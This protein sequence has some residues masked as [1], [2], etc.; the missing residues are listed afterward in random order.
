MKKNLIRLSILFAL[1][2][3][4]YAPLLLKTDEMLHPAWDWVSQHRFWKTF[5]H[6]SFRENGQVPLWAPD[7]FSGAPFVGH[8][9][10][11]T[12]FYPLNF[13]FLIFDVDSV[14]KI[15]LVLHMILA[16]LFM[17]LLLREY[18]FDENISLFGSVVF[19][20]GSAFISKVNYGQLTNFVVVSYLPLLIYLAKKLWEKPT[21][22][23]SLLFGSVWAL[24]FL[25]GNPHLFY[26]CAIGIGL[27]F[28]IRLLSDAMDKKGSLTLLKKGSLVLLAGFI[29]LGL[30]ACQ[31]LP[32]M[33]VAGWSIRNQ[34]D[35]NFS[36]TMS[37]PPYMLVG[38]AFP[39]IF[40][41]IA[42]N[43]YYG[44]ENYT[45]LYSYSGLIALI[46]VL[47]AILFV[48]KR[49]FYLLL[50]IA[51]F[52][53]LLA[54]G[55]Y[56]PLFSIAYK[57]IPGLKLFRIPS[58]FLFLF[59]FFT[60]VLSSYGLRKYI[61][62]I[63]DTERNR[64]TPVNGCPG[65]LFILILF[66]V[67][68]PLQFIIHK[69]KPAINEELIDS[70]IQGALLH[71]VVIY[72]LFLI[73]INIKKIRK[74]SVYIIIG[75]AFLDLAIVGYP[76]L[77]TEEVGAHFRAGEWVRDISNIKGFHRV[78]DLKTIPQHIAQKYDIQKV[79]GTD[80]IILK[81]YFEY[82]NKIIGAVP[83]GTVEQLP[84]MDKSINDIRAAGMLDMLNVDYILSS[85]ETS[86]AE[87]RLISK[88]DDE[89]KTLY[90]YRN[91]Y[92]LPRVWYADEI[93]T[94]ENEEEILNALEN[95]KRGQ[96]IAFITDDNKPD[97][98]PV[99]PVTAHPEIIKYSPN[100]IKIKTKTDTSQLL[101]LSELWFPGWKVRINNK[102]AD[103]L[104][105][106][107][108]FRGVVVPA[109]ESTVDFYYSPETLILGTRITMLFLI[110]VMFF[111]LA[112]LAKYILKSARPY[113]EKKLNS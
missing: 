1:I 7:T 82:T 109:G 77:K 41:S 31:L 105:V 75:I 22:Q 89:G 83:E 49:E 52:V 54:M 57:L 110:V 92:S 93:Q 113:V 3:I 80:P 59:A 90:L 104:R 14:F 34:A 103:V 108:I 76:L 85:D 53:L 70:S 74:Q 20:F 21:I 23:K 51:I 11:S 79:T 107:Y 81:H 64:K 42:N 37:Y 27:Y 72:L 94:R 58:T 96:H 106:N 78:L 71:A 88:Y 87:Y 36:T 6:D 44:P 24:Q 99:A 38:T 102:K 95:I 47:I 65:I 66:M 56:T 45:E 16:G 86:D 2:L 12:Y 26:V 68:K 15:F 43:T 69:L 63:N 46:F 4:F 19:L 10:A 29:L 84:I 50:G 100:R 48:R 30:V 61:E 62:R 28:F 73:V 40:G 112:S 5:E 32:S 55:K 60:A 25:A 8:P 98:N 13:L 67:F 39:D 97:F 111:L 101:V 33:Q 18:E 9:A 35:Y 17:Y 91:L